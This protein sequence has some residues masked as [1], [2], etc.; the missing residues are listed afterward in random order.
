VPVVAFFARSEMNRSPGLFQRST[1]RVQ[2]A[3]IDEFQLDGLIRQ[4]SFKIR[5]SMISR[6]ASHF[7][8]IASGS[9]R[10]APSRKQ[11]QFRDVGC[12]LDR[13]V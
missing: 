4:V 7:G 2:I 10:A 3:G 9:R 13:G 1:Y 6:I 8:L 11:L 12:E 5:E